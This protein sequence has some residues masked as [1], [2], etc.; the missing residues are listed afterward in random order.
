VA[1]IAAVLRRDFTYALLRAVGG[2]DDPALQSALDRLTDAD[3]FIAEN[4]GPQANYRFKHGCCHGNLALA[5][6]SQ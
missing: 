1:Q 6:R 5:E 4:M 3:L 2:V